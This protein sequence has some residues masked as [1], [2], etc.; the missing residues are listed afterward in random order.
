MVNQYGQTDIVQALLKQ[1]TSPSPYKTGLGQAARLGGVALAEWGKR[2]KADESRSALAAALAG[3]NG[4]ALTGEGP[5]T[6]AAGR[7]PIGDPQLMA[8]LL[9]DPNTAQVG[10][11]LLGR[12]LQPAP[13][14]KVIK[15]ADGYSYYQD[16]QDRVLPGVTAPQKQP[17][18]TAAM[19]EYAAA[20]DQGYGGSFLQYQT[21]L[22]RAGRS[23]T[24]VNNNL[25]L[26]KGQEKAD[27]A[28]ATEYNQFI[29]QGGAA[30]MQKNIEQLE[31]VAT[32]LEASDDL[33][34]TLIGAQP[35]WMREAINPESVDTQQAVEE[36]V[37]RNLRLVLGAQ[38]TAEEGNR[39]IARAY[40]PSLD[41]SVN[42]KRIRRLLGAIKKAY[43]AKLAAAQF[44]EKN[45]TLK[46][47][48]G[49]KSFTMHD[50]ERDALLDAEPETGA[51]PAAAGNWFDAPDSVLSTPPAEV[52]QFIRDTDV[53]TLNALPEDV[54][55]AMMKRL[56]RQ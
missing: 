7:A 48:E 17:S 49:V 9:S 22:K 8:R 23:N 16:T 30:D 28:A 52:R 29:L 45:G 4:G 43:S 12:A 15:G 56:G 14:R 5:T 20:K 33:T 37:Q 41:E 36:V 21:D 38:F 46:G 31:E 6:D 19:Q 54:R 24:T 11:A 32:K 53:E 40:N 51:E 50:I 2:K 35:M 44:F 1:G 42:A 13:E 34:G 47:Y 25:D 39:L 26:S 27:T 3:M 55:D 10:Q 18:P